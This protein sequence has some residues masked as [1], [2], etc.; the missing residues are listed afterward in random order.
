MR[1]GKHL[2]CPATVLDT[3]PNNNPASA[4][5]AQ[6]IHTE[7][8]SCLHSVP[9]S[10]CESLFRE[11]RGACDRPADSETR[12]LRRMKSLLKV[13]F[14]NPTLARI[15]SVFLLEYGT[16]GGNCVDIDW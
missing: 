11:T 13:W 3:A 10:R 9:L 12:W 15:S 2:T 14:R 7:T 16:F 5:V 4:G 1:D 8:R 6:A